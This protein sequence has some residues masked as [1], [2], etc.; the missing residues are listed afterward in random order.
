MKVESRR[1]LDRS[2]SGVRLSRR[3]VLAAPFSRPTP[4]KSPLRQE[5]VE[6]EGPPS[7]QWASTHMDKLHRVGNWHCNSRLSSEAQSCILSSY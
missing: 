4:S 2:P 6:Q 3:F 7:P 1:L 5:Q